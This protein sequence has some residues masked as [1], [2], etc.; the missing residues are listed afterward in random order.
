VKKDAVQLRVRVQ[1]G[2]AENKITGYAEGILHIRI[3]APPVQGK[4]NRALTDYLSKLLGVPKSA[5]TVDKGLTSR[6]KTL[7]VAGLTATELA[8]RL[9]DLS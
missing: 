7:A 5:V 6:R 1:P 3:A 2:A 4:A 9:K 8:N